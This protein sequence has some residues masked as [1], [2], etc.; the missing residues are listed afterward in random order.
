MPVLPLSSQWCSCT[1]SRHLIIGERAPWLLLEIVLRSNGRHSKVIDCQ[2]TG[3]KTVSCPASIFNLSIIARCNFVRKVMYEVQ[4]TGENNSN[5]L[6]YSVQSA[7]HNDLCGLLLIDKIAQF[8]HARI[9]YNAQP[10]SPPRW[11]MSPTHPRQIG[12]CTYAAIPRSVRLVV[13]T[14]C[15]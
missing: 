6:R 14:P 5:S 3:G 9:N 10:N 7:N 1:T 15:P 8:L 13:R 2:D 12:C 11:T 4:S